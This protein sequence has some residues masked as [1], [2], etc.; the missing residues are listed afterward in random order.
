MKFTMLINVK[1]H[2]S[3]GIS[4]FFSI[5][6]TTSESWKARNVFIFPNFSLMSNLNFKLRLEFFYKFI[7]GIFFFRFRSFSELFF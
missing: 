1:I 3:V 2:T 6:N 4:M 5:I 7:Y